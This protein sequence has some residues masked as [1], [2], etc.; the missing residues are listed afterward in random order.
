TAPPPHTQTRL[1][2]DGREFSRWALPS[3]RH[4]LLLV[5]PYATANGSL[6]LRTAAGLRCA[7]LLAARRLRRRRTARP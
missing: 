5:R 4:G 1:L 2:R 7:L 6:S 3:A